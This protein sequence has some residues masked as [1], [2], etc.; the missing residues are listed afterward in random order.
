MSLS[1]MSPASWPNS[2]PR[3]E[4]PHLLQTEAGLLFRE[5]MEQAGEQEPSPQVFAAACDG[6]LET[7]LRRRQRRVL[8]QCQVGT[9]PT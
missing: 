3:P 1:P 8:L 4:R 5:L 2:T 7:I 6:A 9:G